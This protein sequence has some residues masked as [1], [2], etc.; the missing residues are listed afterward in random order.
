MVI[1]PQAMMFSPA[2]LPTGKKEARNVEVES[3]EVRS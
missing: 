1:G 3:W 2:A